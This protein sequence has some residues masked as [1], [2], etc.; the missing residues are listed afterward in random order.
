MPALTQ[1]AARNQNLADLMQQ[2]YVACLAGTNPD[3]SV[4]VLPVQ[5]NT[6][7]PSGQTPIT[8]TSGNVAASAAVST[9]AGVAGKTTYITGFTCTALG[10]T[11]AAAVTVTVTGLAAGTL[12][13]TFLFPTGATVQANPLTITFANSLPASAQNTAI[14]VTLPSGG[15]GNTNAASNAWGFQQ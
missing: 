5:V 13:F 8:A 4:F 9:L 7:T 11:A 1:A 10:A 3:G 6:T 2:F 15:A 14:V 12:N